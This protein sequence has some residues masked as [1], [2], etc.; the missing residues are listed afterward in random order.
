MKPMTVGLAAALAL[1]PCVGANAQ[2][3]MATTSNEHPADQHS[4][5]E[6]AESRQPEGPRQ[7]DIPSRQ[8]RRAPSP[9]SSTT[10]TPQPIRTPLQ[11]TEYFVTLPKGKGANDFA[12][13]AGI[14][15]G[16]P[17]FVIRE[18]DDRHALFA[19]DQTGIAEQL[20]KKLRT[21]GLPV[22]RVASKVST[23]MG[24]TP[25]PGL[26]FRYSEI[27]K[28]P[29]TLFVFHDALA[30]ISNPDQPDKTM[31]YKELAS[32]ISEKTS[33]PTAVFAGHKTGS[34]VLFPAGELLGSHLSEKIS[35]FEGA[36]AERVRLARPF[37]TIN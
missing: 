28:L 20:E 31:A 8:D 17:V 24:R 16:L 30:K 9:M 21:F 2:A 13:I 18:I 26:H 34:V 12:K 4:N 11:G 19:V 23:V 6:Q 14:A 22:E 7:V 3:P 29:P 32:K 27:K 5:S 15:A 10:K 35:G 33:L 1:L 37:S 25:P 36:R